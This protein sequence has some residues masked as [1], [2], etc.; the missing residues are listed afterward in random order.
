MQTLLNG[1]PYFDF[2]L[3]YSRSFLKTTLDWKTTFC[4]FFVNKKIVQFS[5]KIGKFSD[6]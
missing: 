6:L 2:F 5:L 1:G 4:R 3:I